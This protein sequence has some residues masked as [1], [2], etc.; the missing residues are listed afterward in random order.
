M[1]DLGCGDGTFAAQFKEKAI[2]Q[3]MD[4]QVIAAGANDLK[5]AN[6]EKI[7]K[8]YYGFIPQQTQLLDDFAGQCGLVVETYGPTTYHKNPAH[9]IA[10]ALYL[11]ERT[12]TYSCISS[13]TKDGEHH[14]VFGNRKA[15]N[16]VKKSFIDKF[17][18][19]IS[20]I[21]TSIKSQV[22]FK[23]DGTPA[24]VNDCLLRVRFKGH[25]YVGVSDYETLCGEI[26]EKLGQPEPENTSWFAAGG[27]EFSI[28]A[29]NYVTE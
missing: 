28:T 22:R 25:N 11:L 4:I 24:I 3:K 5:P 9:V 20:L 15:F 16:C 19:N 17:D 12:G 13:T 26:D 29:K 7:D 23:E 8:I 1:A 18:A 2:Q 6:I 14:S 10:Y 27:S 21:Y